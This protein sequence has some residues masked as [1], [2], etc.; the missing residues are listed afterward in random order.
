VTTKSSKA[1]HSAIP[2]ARND[3]R[4]KNPIPKHLEA[5]AWKPGQVPN[6]RG[7]PI[8]SRSKFSEAMVSDF[9]AD[10]HEHGTDVLARVR[11][12][13]PAVYLRVAAVLVP[14]ELNVAVEQKTPGNISVEDWKLIIDLVKLIKASSPPGAEAVPSELIPV[15]EDSIRAHFA[16]PVSE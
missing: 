3:I 5:T 4:P 8:G 11:A 13:E 1:S 10:W 12:T 16:K 14:K 15:I 9:L 7:R 6:P 2:A